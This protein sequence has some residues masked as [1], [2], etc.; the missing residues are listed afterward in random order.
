MTAPIRFVLADACR[1]C[2]WEYG[3]NMGGSTWG[4]LELKYDHP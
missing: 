4:V 1:I 3:G 2:Q